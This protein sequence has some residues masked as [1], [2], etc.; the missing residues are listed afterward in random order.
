M[1]SRLLRTI[2]EVVLIFC[3]I[4]YAYGAEPQLIIPPG[5]RLPTKLEL[6]DLWR[7]DDTNRF[8]VANGDFDTDGTTDLAYLLVSKRDKRVGLFTSLS[9]NPSGK[10]M[11][12]AQE[13]NPMLIQVMGVSTIKPGKYRSA[14]GKG[15]WDCVKGES[16]EI[17][18]DNEALVYF[19]HES[20]SSY[21]YWDKPSK[22]LKRVWISD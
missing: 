4:V 3:T 6:S 16:E 5:W 8:A 19:K 11:L 17:Q 22:S 20:S 15:Y 12:L 1:K 7:T 18:L 21:F 10:P 13:A 14:C 9:R 2:S